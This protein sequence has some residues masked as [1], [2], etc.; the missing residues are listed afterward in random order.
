MTEL[1]DEAGHIEAE[2]IVVTTEDGVVLTG[3]RLTA[4]EARIVARMQ[5][6]DHALF[7]C[8]AVLFVLMVGGAFFL[9]NLSKTVNRTD[10][11]L[12]DNTGPKA[13]A[14]SATIIKSLIDS[15]DC[16]EQRNLQR[17]IA[18][19]NESETR[20]NLAITGSVVQARC[21]P[22]TTIAPATTSTTSS[23]AKTSKKSTTLAPLATTLRTTTTTISSRTTVVV[24]SST[25][26]T[27]APPEST[28]TTQAQATTSSTRRCLPTVIGDIC[29]R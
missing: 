14:Q 24:S 20:S 18:K 7:G 5:K 25:T 29:P 10:R 22:T 4:F 16:T 28:T 21:E 23:A 11:T 15:F 19:I 1:E 8:I 2:T 17:L 12:K 27:R 9:G 26:T 3:N 6:R 13:Q